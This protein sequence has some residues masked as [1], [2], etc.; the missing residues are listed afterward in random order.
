MRPSRS[1]KITA[2]EAARMI[3]VQRSFNGAFVPIS[4]AFVRIA[5]PLTEVQAE[6]YFVRICLTHRDCT[7]GVLV[8]I[9]TLITTRHA[10]ARETASGRPFRRGA[11]RPFAARDLHIGRVVVSRID[12]TRPRVGTSAVRERNRKDVQMELR[13]L[14]VALVALSFAGAAAAAGNTTGS[15]ANNSSND[16]MTTRQTSPQATQNENGT[17]STNAMGSSQNSASQGASSSQ[18]S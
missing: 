4:A 14:A 5:I 8:I 2:S 16:Q 18:G 17:S 10:C 7:H 9:A 15:T 6:V 1:A 13:K 12:R 3:F 11:R